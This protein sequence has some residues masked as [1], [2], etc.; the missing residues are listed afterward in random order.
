MYFSFIGLI[1]NCIR[2]NYIMRIFLFIFI[3][4]IMGGFMLVGVVRVISCD[5]NGG[6]F[7]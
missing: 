4:L 1:C 5:E 3:F 7:V 2:K 6:V